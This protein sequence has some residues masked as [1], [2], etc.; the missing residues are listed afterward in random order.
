MPTHAYTQDIVTFFPLTSS[1]SENM[2]VR[3][4]QDCFKRKQGYKE[5]KGARER[6]RDERK[7]ERVCVSSVRA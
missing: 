7:R 4:M 2:C 3:V 6:E 1:S 5:R